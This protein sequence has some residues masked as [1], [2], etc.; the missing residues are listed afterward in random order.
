MK[1][2]FCGGKLEGIITP[3]SSKSYTHRA[4]FLGSLA[5]GH[6]IMSNALLSN[7]TL[8]TI[9]ACEAIGAKITIE[10]DRII[11]DGGKLHAPSEVINTDNSG[12]TMRIFTGLAS[13]FNTRIEITGDESL[14]KRPMEPLLDALSQ[15]GVECTSNNG[16]PPVTVKGYNRGGK[17]TIDGGISSQFITALFMTAPMLSADS[18]IVIT[19]KMISEPYL[20]VTMKMM[21]NFGVHTNK[22]DNI[23]SIHGNSGYKPHNFKIPADF[24][25]AAFMLVA[26]ALNGKITVTSLDMTDPQ[27]DRRII[28]IL[29]MIGVQMNIDGQN[30]A[31]EMSSLKAI[32]LDMGAIP[33]LFP[34]VATLLAT[35]HGTSRLYGAPQLKLKES[36]RIE[37]TVNM[38]KTI[39]ADIEA[40]DDGCI[41]RGKEKLTGGFIDNKGDHRIMMAAAV[42][43]LSCEGP[44]I[45]ENAECCAVS[46]PAFIYQMKTLGMKVI[47]E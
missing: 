9:H 44:V 25:S 46:Y 22:N 24:S 5:Q 37:T 40:T 7:D 18:E 43:S 8:A 31:V 36:N 11:I 27:G 47:E 1:I 4:I 19:G 33:D 29:K 2:S 28:D 20:D 16:K 34:I 17:V 45:M 21:E 10:G 30:I 26:G 14:Q 41:I 38:L 3:P 12:T 42:A 39:G 32:E 35:A 13:M 6:S 15:C 23:Y